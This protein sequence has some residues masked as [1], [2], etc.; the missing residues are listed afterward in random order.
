MRDHCV[1]Y[2]RGVALTPTV[3]NSITACEPMRLT[4]RE[5]VT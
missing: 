2:G 3:E 1:V 5:Y 4:R